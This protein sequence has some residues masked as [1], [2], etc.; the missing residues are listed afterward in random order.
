MK[1]NLRF[2]TKI[3]E[4]YRR[5]DLG[6]LIFAGLIGLFTGVLT[7]AL[8]FL[9]RYLSHLFYGFDE[10]GVHMGGGIPWYVIMLIPAI[11]GLVV[12]F[13]LNKLFPDA[14]GHG[15]PDVIESVLRKGGV[16]KPATIWGKSLASSITISTGGSAGMEGPI[17]QIGGAIGSAIGQFFKV[18][19]KQLQTLVA[20]GTAAG[21]GAVFNAPM[22]GAIFAAEV[23]IGNFSIQN[24]SPIIIASV[25]G[26]SVTHSV[27]GDY[28]AFT[29]PIFHLTSNWEYIFYII[30]GSLTG[31]SAAFFTRNF[32]RVEDIFNKIK[33]PP[34]LKPA[35]GGLMVGSIGIFLPHILGPG[36]DTI[37]LVLDGNIVFWIMLVLILVKM[38]ATSFTLGSGGSGGIFAPSFFIG[39]VV[40]G[41][42]GYLVNLLLPESSSGFGSYALIGMGGFLAGLIHAPLASILMI[43]EI[44]GN[45]S[46]ILP[47][48][49]TCMI[50][51]I[52]ARSFHKE[53]FFTEP[54]IKKGIQ[55][56]KGRDA[57]VLKNIPVSEVMTELDSVIDVGEKLN[58]VLAK[59]MNS[60]RTLYFI[61]D[62]QKRLRGMI[63]FNDIKSLMS[64]I[65]DM[66]DVLLASDI[67][68]GVPYICHEEDSLDDV[69]K[70]IPKEKLEAVPVLDK[71]DRLCGILFWHRIIETYNN[72]IN[73][74]NLVNHLFEDIHEIENRKEIEVLGSN[75]MIEIQ[76]PPEFIGKSIKGLDLRKKHGISILALKIP[77]LNINKADIND[78]SPDPNYIFEGSEQ[79]VFLIPSNRLKNFP[80]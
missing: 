33:I 58:V 43:F 19:S 23:I 74:L 68:K 50:S 7:V 28:P 37:Q 49:F 39:A 64:T 77:G 65:E 41:S 38:L 69:L 62:G 54:L 31:L 34:F 3:V 35:L 66:G 29:V 70:A 80:Y 20:A 27:F 63:D 51:T 57:N 11:G 48:M 21:I 6:M 12:W 1:I 5:E 13:I 61:T 56:S 45:Y 60:R 30:L 10:P 42:F 8:I 36:Y 18:D 4:K 26:T 79:I 52:V 72:E 73:K 44:T 59:I 14:E 32:F 2:L 24:F 46:S 40:G 53:S 15:V 25:V 22:A 17:V 78:F 76:V 16:I 75:K 67:A 9:L 55:L 71:E 47:L